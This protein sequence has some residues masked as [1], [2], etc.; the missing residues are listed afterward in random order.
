MSFCCQRI[1]FTCTP[2]KL[3]VAW[4]A[5]APVSPR[6]LSVCLA[7]IV[8]VIHKDLNTFICR[9]LIFWSF[10]HLTEGCNGRLN[11]NYP[12]TQKLENCSNFILMLWLSK[13]AATTE[14]FFFFFQLAFLCYWLVDTIFL[15]SCQ[16]HLHAPTPKA[17]LILPSLWVVGSVRS[18]SLHECKWV[19]VSGSVTSSMAI[20]AAFRIHL[21]Q[22]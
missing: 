19:V 15:T 2:L 8:T 7:S 5:S 14:T 11:F 21:N 10:L 17:H 1:M 4:V 13:A 3:S 9:T 12:D 6:W 18:L 16:Y 20:K 22:C